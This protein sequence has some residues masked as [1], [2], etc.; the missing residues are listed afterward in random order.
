MLPCINIASHFNV[1]VAKFKPITVAVQTKR[2]LSSA[3]PT[4]GSWARIQRVTLME[5]CV[6]SLRCPV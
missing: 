4:L 2:I 6:H 5:D 3:A 1:D